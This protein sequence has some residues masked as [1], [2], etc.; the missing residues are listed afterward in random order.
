MVGYLPG[1][2]RQDAVS[3]S[4]NGPKVDKHSKLHGDIRIAVREWL[5]EERLWLCTNSTPLHK[6]GYEALYG[7]ATLSVQ[8]A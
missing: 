3:Y 7:P 6:K 2:N 1:S 4:E 8:V 5:R